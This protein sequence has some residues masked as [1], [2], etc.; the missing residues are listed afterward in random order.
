MSRRLGIDK[1]FRKKG[2]LQISKVGYNSI[3][4]RK[5]PTKRR[6]VLQVL[7]N[8][9][10]CLISSRFLLS[11]QKIV[12]IHRFELLAGQR[13]LEGREL[14]DSA[15]DSRHGSVVREGLVVKNQ[16]LQGPFLNSLQ[17]EAVRAVDRGDDFDRA[18]LQGDRFFGAVPGADAAAEADGR[19]D[20][21]ALFGRTG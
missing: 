20:D 1:G 19:V 6:R 10:I 14:Q 8:I 16:I 3:Y 21:G 18:A 9:C 11:G 2:I 15:E 17:D 13:L 5:A 4:I 12:Q 7:F